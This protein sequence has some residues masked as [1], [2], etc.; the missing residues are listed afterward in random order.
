MTF[1]EAQIIN[2]MFGIGILT[3]VIVVFWIIAR[4]AQNRGKITRAMNMKLFLITMPEF[5]EQ[6]EK[7]QKG[8]KERDPK[9]PIAVMEQFYASLASLRINPIKA[10][11]YG[12]PHFVLELANKAGGQTFFY[13]A[14]PEKFSDIIEK[15]I[16][17]FFPDAIIEDTEDYTIFEPTSEIAGAV[18][19]LQR[20]PFLPIKTYQ[21]LETDPLNNLTNALSKQNAKEGAAIQILM[22]PRN[23][24]RLQKKGKDVAQEMQQGK[25][26]RDAKAAKRFFFGALKSFIKSA[27]SKDRMQDDS[28]RLTPAQEETVKALE[29]KAT[30][31]GFDAIVRIITAA[32]TKE[33]AKTNLQHITTS[34]TQFKGMELNSFKIKE[35]IS[36]PLLQRFEYNFIFRNFQ[37]ENAIYLNT[38]ELTSIIHFPV[39]TTETPT[40]KR[41]ESKEAPPPN[42]VP[43]EGTL[44]GHSKYRGKDIDIRITKKDRGRHMYVIGK[45]GS[46]K[47]VSLMNYIIQDIKDGAGVCVMDPHGELAEGVLNFI[48]KERADDVIIFDPSDT[49]RPLGLNL[50]E[51]YDDEQKDLVALEAMNIM[52]KLF[53]SEIFSPRLQDYFRNGALTL[54][55]DNNDLGTLIDIVRLFTND[56]F[57]RE[58]VAKVTNPV[59]RDFW[60]NQMAKTGQREKEEMIPFWASKFGQFITNATMRNILGQKKSAI[61][62]RKAMDEGKIILVNLAK[63]KI[64]EINMKLLGMIIV[65][66]IQM[67]ALS[68]TDIPENKRRDF[69]LHVDEFQNF[70]TDTFESILSEARKYHLSLTIAHQYIGQIKEAGSEFGGKVDLAAAVFGNVGTII[71][72]RVGTEDAEFLEQVFEP[73]FTKSDIANIGK[74][75]ALTRLLIENT[76]SKPFNMHMFPPPEG[77]NAKIGKAI[78]ELSR[79]KHGRPK[80]IIDAEILERIQGV[81]FGKQPPNKKP[82]DLLGF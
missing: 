48:P 45:T 68:R 82:Q 53:G 31:A 23:N 79:L 72:M 15:Q 17:S 64:G 70:A 73:T 46:G 41:L 74:H 7:E 65:A 39:Q 1:D 18:V 13:V 43:Q 12:Q 63:G 51:A 40:L 58:R 71:A 44:L 47:S 38:E 66:K 56:E 75:Q 25:T 35:M 69:Y 20:E 29:M 24:A 4:I 14:A 57:Q 50:L 5:T 67:A 42:N 33:R 21:L 81:R 80:E 8:G 59:V 52:L 16:H 36:G 27:R 22:R 2:A 60:E 78:R 6:Q 77:G 61:D 10:Y 26:Y 62:F 3:A 32:E 9:E 34:F 76:D 11:I 30:K 37:R 55:A 28:I 49:K 19:Q 54:M